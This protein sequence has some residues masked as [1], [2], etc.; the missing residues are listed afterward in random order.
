MTVTVQDIE[1]PVI[2]CPADI[3]I[4]ST[5]QVVLGDA[6]AIDNCGIAS[7][8]NNAPS[9]FTPGTTLVVWTATDIYG[10]IDSCQR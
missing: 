9:T 6:T 2:T 10:N 1:S 5:E 4:C 8:T 7:I 3:L